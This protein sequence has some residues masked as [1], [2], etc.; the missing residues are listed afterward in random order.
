M[1]AM[2]DW[3]HE[4]G[5]KFGL[6][7]SMGDATCNPGGRPRDIPGSYGHYADDAQTFADWGMDYVKADWCG[8]KLTD[9]EKQHTELSQGLNA[10]GRPIF[11]ELCRGYSY[12]PIPEYVA[13][14]ANGWRTTGDHQDEWSNTK[15]VIESFF[16]PSNPGVPHAW[17]Y[18]DFLMVGGPGC[19]VNTSEHCPRSSDDE[20]RTEFA[21]W[22]IAA[23]PLIVATDIRNMT[24][25]MKQTLLNEEALFINQ[26]HTAPAGKKVA[27]DASCGTPLGQCPVMHRALSDGTHAALL[28]NLHDTTERKIT[29]TWD[30]LGIESSQSLAL[31]DVL[32]RKPLGTFSSSFTS[33]PLK[34]HE[35]LFLRLSSAALV[36]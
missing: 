7:T 11:F 25:V 28:I 13:Q 36:V 24:A 35:S 27:D 2:A 4:R 15:K 1:K 21:V 26:D 8:K 14:V 33:P 17:N 29:L 16:A 6:Y 9:A 22:T 32:A 20:Y 23:S 34:P 30:M 31:R 5:L 18:G 3:L 12:K 19:N 10:T